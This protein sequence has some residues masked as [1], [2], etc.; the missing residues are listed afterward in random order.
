MARGRP[1][2]R[3]VK[4]IGELFPTAPRRLFC[5]HEYIQVRCEM[6]KEL[7]WSFSENDRC[8]CAIHVPEA[9]TDLVD[10]QHP[11]NP[12]RHEQAEF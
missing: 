2:Q 6:C 7:I 3:R 12:V 10:T 4:T 5:G 9:I 8:L 11:I 1:E